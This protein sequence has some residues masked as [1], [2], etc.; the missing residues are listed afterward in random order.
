MQN[1][2][3]KLDDL[4]R[5]IQRSAG[6]PDCF[7]RSIAPCDKVDCIWRSLCLDREDNPDIKEL[8]VVNHN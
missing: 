5:S 7:R 1:N 3:L 8:G 2:Y 6:D 4:V